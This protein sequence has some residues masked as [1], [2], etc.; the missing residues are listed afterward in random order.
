ME[1]IK[2]IKLFK[3]TNEIQRLITLRHSRNSRH[4][5][6]EFILEGR[7]AIDQAYK[8]GW[9]VKALFYNQDAPLSNWAQQHLAQK[10]YDSAYEITASL[11]DKIADK[12]ESSELIAIAEM[13]IRPFSSYFPSSPEVIV[14]LDTPKSAGNV[15]MMIRSAVCFGAHAVVLSGHAADEYDPKCIR[16][17]VG[18]FFSIPIYRVE[19]INKFLEKIEDLKLRTSV[20]IMASG[21]KGAL[22]IEEA[23]FEED[24]L[25][26]VLGN[27]TKGVSAGYREAAHQFVRISTANEFTSLNVA[28]AGSIFLYEIFRQKK[29]AYQIYS[30]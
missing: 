6:Q 15:G 24:L 30:V 22:S 9:R 21:D 25:F 23:K 11:M 20:M 4:H 29:A 19:G 3:E 28:A 13:Q 2:T 10:R 7:V 27:E 12:T 16:A 14:V 26:L 5:Y 17:S 18:T 1:Q 8:K